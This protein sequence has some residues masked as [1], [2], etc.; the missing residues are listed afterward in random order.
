[1]QWRALQRLQLV[2]SKSKYGHELNTGLC[3]K[4][5]CC[6]RRCYKCGWNRPFVRLKCRCWRMEEAEKKQPKCNHNFPER[7][8]PEDDYAI[9]SPAP[10]TKCGQEFDGEYEC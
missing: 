2:C 10:C 3:F 7:H 1:M 8:S 4:E 5:D 9:S 6:K